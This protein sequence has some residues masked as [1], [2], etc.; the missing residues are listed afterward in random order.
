MSSESDS[1]KEAKTN[2]GGQKEDCCHKTCGPHTMAF[3]IRVQIQQV[4]MGI[5]TLAALIFIVV[6]IL[7]GKAALPGNPVLLVFVFFL[8]VYLLALNEG[9]QIAILQGNK[10]KLSPATRFLPSFHEAAKCLELVEGIRLQWWLGGRQFFVICSVFVVAQVT[11]F[12]DMN[13]WPWTD[14]FWNPPATT[15]TPVPTTAGANVLNTTAGLTTSNLVVVTG[16][17]NPEG[18]IP[19][20]F[21]IA[22]LQTGVLGALVVVIIGQLVPQLVAVPC[23]ILFFSLPGSHLILQIGLFFPLH[24]HHLHCFLAHHDRAVLSQ[25]EDSCHCLSRRNWLQNHGPYPLHLLHTGV[26]R[27]SFFD[28]VWDQLRVRQPT[29]CLVATRDYP[30]RHDD[31]SRLPRGAPSRFDRRQKVRGKTDPVCAIHVQSDKRG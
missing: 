18:L 26:P 27:L 28:G 1:G 21:R 19:E 30:A 5:F 9:L 7:G 6:C 4:I 20:W 29:R 15:T 3:K 13:Y 23:P 31:H 16:D 17:S 25:A 14:E 10:L 12:N 2:D 24:R 8:G 11:T 22:V